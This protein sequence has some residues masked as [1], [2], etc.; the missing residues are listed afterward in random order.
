MG[1]EL[2]P[3]GE[4]SEFG[5]YP[6]FPAEARAVQNPRPLV[7]KPLCEV[8][9][10]HDGDRCATTPQR[11]KGLLTSLVVPAAMTEA[12]EVQRAFHGATRSAPTGGSGSRNPV[13]PRH[14]ARPRSA[15]EPNPASKPHCLRGAQE[16]P[17]SL[18]PAGPT[19]QRGRSID[20]DQEQQVPAWRR[21]VA[22]CRRRG[23]H[24]CRRLARDRA[25]D[26]PL[27][28]VESV[29]DRRRSEEHHFGDRSGVGVSTAN[30]AP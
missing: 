5:V 13:I 12:D 1:F 2:S 6:I 22:I 8:V 11:S 25:A 20:V 15:R 29:R 30:A 14:A 21:D 10:E 7:L 24:L 26:I 18:M 3:V 4:R 27:I 16:K 23:L 28:V 17:S 9:H 19:G